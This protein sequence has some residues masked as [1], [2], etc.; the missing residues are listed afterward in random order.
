MSAVVGSCAVSGKTAFCVFSFLFFPLL[1][2]P[3]MASFSIIGID[4]LPAQSHHS[5]LVHMYYSDFLFLV[6]VHSFAS[7]GLDLIKPDSDVVTYD[8][9]PLQLKR[10]LIRTL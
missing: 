6:Y 5:P 8:C 10:V 2:I 7:R 4:C 1:F 9:S 3:L